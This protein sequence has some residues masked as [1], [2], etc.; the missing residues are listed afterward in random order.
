M[1][2]TCD[3]GRWVD[4]HFPL[5]CFNEL[6]NGWDKADATVE[7]LASDFAT[8]TDLSN[9]TIARLHESI[10]AARLEIDGLRS[11]ATGLLRKVDEMLAAD[12]NEPEPGSPAHELLPFISALRASLAAPGDG[13]E[14][15][16][17]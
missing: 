7:K 6:R 3:C 13:E 16:R 17:G 1:G 10:V 15:S 14:K 12:D 8:M 11:A 9:A 5:D 2:E 4:D